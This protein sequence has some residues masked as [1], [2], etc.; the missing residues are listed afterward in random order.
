MTLLSK[1]ILNGLSALN[2]NLDAAY[3]IQKED[4]AYKEDRAAQGAPRQ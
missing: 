3:K 4:L 2:N 1:T